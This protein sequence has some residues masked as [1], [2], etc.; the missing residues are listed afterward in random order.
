MIQRR[1]AYVRA[2]QNGQLG[3]VEQQ[4]EEE[5]TEAEGVR[6]LEGLSNKL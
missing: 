1:S 5:E 6:M 4:Q 3:E 2:W